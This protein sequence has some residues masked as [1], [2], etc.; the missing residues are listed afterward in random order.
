[1]NCN[2]E[3]ESLMDLVLG[4]TTKIL[5][6]V[7]TILFGAGLSFLCRRGRIRARATENPQF[8]RQYVT[9][10]GSLP[11]VNLAGMAEGSNRESLSI[12]FITKQK[13]DPY[14][15]SS[16]ITSSSANIANIENRPLNHPKAW[17]DLEIPLLEALYDFSLF[18]L[19]RRGSPVKPSR[20]SRVWNHSCF[21]A[22]ISPLSYNALIKNELEYKFSMSI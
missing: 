12:S 5:T 22:G 3:M 4:N 20:K 1:M 18:Y 6:G 15:H 19:A 13:R 16:M 17:F 11:E 10:D 2:I 7:A 8:L 21:L 9:D 14:W